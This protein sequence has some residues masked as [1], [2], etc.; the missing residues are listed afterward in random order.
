MDT[1]TTIYAVGTFVI[2]ALLWAAARAYRTRLKDG[3]RPP[4]PSPEREL[5]IMELF[6]L[7]HYTP[8]MAERARTRE[9]CRRLG[10]WD[11]R[12]EIDGTKNRMLRAIME[13]ELQR[14]ID[15]PTEADRW[16]RIG[17]C[18]SNID[19]ANRELR[20]SAPVA[21]VEPT[22]IQEEPPAVAVRLKTDDFRHYLRGLKYEELREMRKLSEPLVKMRRAELNRRSQ[23]ARRA[24][25]KLGKMRDGPTHV[26]PP[27]MTSD[28]V[29]RATMLTTSQM[30]G[31]DANGSPVNQDAIE[32]AERTYQGGRDV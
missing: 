8:T 1:V 15:H 19:Q 20:E 24:L 9:Y 31:W 10:Y 23:N 5:D 11:L 12:K 32:R 17:R 26:L 6:A 16:E 21:Q 27:T 7:E 4:G 25:V 29:C 3:C 2:G 22:P 14:R 30:E 18:L 13:V 28:D